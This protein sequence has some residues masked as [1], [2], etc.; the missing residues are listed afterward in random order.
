MENVGKSTLAFWAYNPKFDFLD[1]FSVVSRLFLD[2]AVKFLPFF[3][4]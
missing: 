3:G 2:N 4:A 1:V